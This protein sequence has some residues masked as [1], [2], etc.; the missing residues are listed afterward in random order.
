MRNTGAFAFITALLLNTL[1]RIG[2]QGATAAYLRRSDTTETFY[3]DQ[4]VYS[5]VL[6]FV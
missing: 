3:P 1:K 6:R 2:V 4:I 5:S